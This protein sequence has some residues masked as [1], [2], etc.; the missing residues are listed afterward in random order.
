MNDKLTPE[1]LADVQTDI[2]L[3]IFAL[4][5]VAIA[6]LAWFIGMYWA[7]APS[8]AYWKSRTDLD[9]DFEDES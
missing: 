9:S 7:S 2:N 3:L 5:V 6:M 8:R 4:L 1:Q